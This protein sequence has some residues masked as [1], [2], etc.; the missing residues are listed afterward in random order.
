[1]KMDAVLLAGGTLSADDPLFHESVAGY[2]SLTNI[3]GKPMAQWVI[4]ALAGS[5]NVGD[6]YVMG[7]PEEYVFN[8]TKPLHFLQEQGGIFKN[9]QAGVQQAFQDHPDREKVLICSADIPALR[10]EMVDWLIDQVTAD[11]T[12]QL[13]Y[14]VVCQPVM[15]SRF[16][17]ANRTFIRFKDVAVCGGDLNVVDQSFFASEQ[18][19]W[20]QLI[21]ARKSPLK[22]A[23]MLG[24]ITLLLVGCHMITLEDTVHRVCNKLSIDARALLNPYAQVAMDADKPHQLEIL[25]S[26]LAV[27][28]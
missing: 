1:M 23:G 9:V 8:G 6:L 2:R 7:L 16:P 13:Y 15:D 11:P 28:P 4:D 26:Y 21:A 5:D 19:L 10:T 24:I 20:N 3:H 17:T 22:Q 27:Q 14:N 12:A 25:R 18:P